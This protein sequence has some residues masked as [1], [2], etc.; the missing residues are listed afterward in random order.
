MNIL[1][2]CVKKE[3]FKYGGVPLSSP[4]WSSLSYKSPIIIAP[5]I[6]QCRRQPC[7]HMPAI[8][9]LRAPIVCSVNGV[10]QNSRFTKY[11][12]PHLPRLERG[13]FDALHT[14]TETTKV[15]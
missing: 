7:T 2:Q 14:N 4:D 6:S 13:C 9:Q 12:A 10:E 5:S 3:F 15:I 8:H 11:K 1:E